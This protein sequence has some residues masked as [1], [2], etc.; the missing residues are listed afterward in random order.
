MNREE[1][2]NFIICSKKEFYK[3]KEGKSKRDFLYDLELKEQEKFKEEYIDVSYVEQEI[4]EMDE[5]HRLIKKGQP[6]KNMYLKFI[7]GEF[8]FEGIVD[9][10]DPRTNTATLF[11]PLSDRDFKSFVKE[12]KRVGEAKNKLLEI[13]Y[14]HFL[15]KENDLDINFTLNTINT[16][17][18]RGRDNLISK[19]ELKEK[20]KLLLPDVETAIKQIKALKTEPDPV[21]INSKC[22]NCSYYSNCWKDLEI[23]HPYFIPKLSE[24]KKKT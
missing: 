23:S 16:Y 3:N 8:L 7:S 15:A 11:I 20:T 21:Y 24:G 9:L 5:T 14:L 6:V 4:R 12:N 18:N 13:G 1:F 22:R 2:Y 19:I 17:F 10:Y